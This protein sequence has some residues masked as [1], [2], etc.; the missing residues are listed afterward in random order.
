M[1]NQPRRCT[2]DFDQPEQPLQLARKP[3]SMPGLGS[4]LPGSKLAAV[5]STADGAAAAAGML[6]LLSMAAALPLEDHWILQMNAATLHKKAV[7]SKR[8]ADNL[9]QVLASA[10]AAQGRACS[11]GR[12]PD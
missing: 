2:D 9:K 5:V 12:V 10:Q 7:D 4:R 1:H 3:C 6:K 8:Q 11:I